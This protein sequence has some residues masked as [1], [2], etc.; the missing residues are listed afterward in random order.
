[1]KTVYKNGLPVKYSFNSTDGGVDK[2]FEMMTNDN[3]LIHV[4]SYKDNECLVAHTLNKGC[5]IVVQGGILK[6][7]KPFRLYGTLKVLSG[8]TL[9]LADTFTVGYDSSLE[10][11]PMAECEFEVYDGATLI[12]DNC[13]LKCLYNSKIKIHKYAIVIFQN[14]TSGIKVVD[15]AVTEYQGKYEDPQGVVHKTWEDVPYIDD[16]Y[17]DPIALLTAIIGDNSFTD[18]GYVFTTE[19]QETADAEA[20]LDTLNGEVISSGN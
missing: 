20:L 5:D 18:A 19:A 13:S 2:C 6:L 7:N 12:I 11:D 14:S 3:S 8:C 17:I 10:V 16:E 15:T 9:H 1:M 4:E